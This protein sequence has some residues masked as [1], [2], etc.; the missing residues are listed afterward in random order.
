MEPE[1]VVEV[2]APAEGR[3]TFG[4]GYLVD[5]AFVLTAGHLLDRAAGGACEVR[6]L[7]TSEWRPAR[8]RWR[9]AGCDAALLA[10]ESLGVERARLGRLATTARAA[11]RAVGFPLA[12]AVGERRDTEAIAGTIEPLSAVKSGLLM[13]Q[14]ESGPPQAGPAG[15]EGMSGA[16]LW[17]GSLLVGV[18]V[19][20]PGGFGA[21]RVAAVPVAVMAEEPGFAAALGESPVLEAVEDVAAVAGV[22][23]DAYRPFP[24]RELWGRAASFLLEPEYGV[25]PFH[26]R[27]DELA[28]L[29]AWCEGDAGLAVGLMIGPGGAGKT[30][31]AAE[32][33]LR[34]R[35]QG[36]PA[37]MLL[38]G[39]Q[40]AELTAVSTPLLVVVDEAH[41]RKSRPSASASAARAPRSVCPTCRSRSSRPSC[42]S[43]SRP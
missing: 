39:A 40:L 10:V 4:S 29:D 27:Q 5:G 36:S 20:V 33:C 21:Q 14:V 26:G 13:V 42:S 2:W 12:Q 30:R 16:A 28:D 15:W 17:V 41:S 32:L 35:A 34:R 23:A 22:L 31:L 18:I 3:G 9:G 43:I 37:G 25:V 6:P 19:V 24:A 7:G 8:L 1:R 11:C 38:A